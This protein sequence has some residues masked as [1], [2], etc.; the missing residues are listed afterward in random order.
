MGRREKPVDPA[1]GPVQRFAFELRKLRQEAGGPT[2]RAMARDAGYSVAAL[3]AAASGEKLP[4]LPVALAYAEAC[5][6]DRGEWE[7][8]WR[9]AADEERRA[10]G[11]GEDDEDGAGPPYRGL[12]RYEPGDSELFF[13]RDGLV[14]DLVELALA[15]RCVAVLGPS[16][17][18]K[19]SLLRAGLIPRL[20]QAREGLPR[21]AAIR[22]LTPGARP[23]S[24]HRERL[25]P[26]A[27]DGDTWVVVDQFE[28]VFTLCSDPAER[29][30][31]VDALLAAEAPGSRLRVVLGVR[32]DFYGRCLRHRGLTAVLS[33]AS[34][35]VGP[36]GAEELRQV[37]V[38][39]AAARGLVVERALTATLVAEAGGDVGGLPLMSH[40]LLETWRRRRGR[41]LTM[42]GY[43]A[44]GGLHGA[45]AQTAEGL[46]ARLTPEQ[47]LLVRRVLLRLVAPG[48][49]APDTR[50]PAGRA[51]L[52]AALGDGAGQ[53]LERLCRARLITLDGHGVELAHEALL[54]AWPRL[55]GW[56]EEDRRRLVLRHR[57]ARAADGWREVGRD[58]GALYRGLRLA[59]AL[60]A[61][62]PPGGAVDLAPGEREFLLASRA[63][64]ARERR[65]HRASVAAV[66]AVV[67]LALLAGVVAW[68]ENREGDRRRAEAGA[69][70][71]AVL[72]ASMR[73]SD[74]VL[75][76]RL[77]VAAWRVSDTAETR[78][79]LFDA[80]TQAHQD[81]LPV[82][83]DVGAGQ[84]FLGAEGRT[85]TT[86]SPNAGESFK[87]GAPL[88][89]WDVPARE[90]ATSASVFLPPGSQ[91]D[92][93]PDG[94]LV[95][96]GSE[97]AVSVFDVSSGDPVGADLRPAGGSGP[98]SAAFNPS[99]RTVTV[100][101]NGSLRLWDVERRRPLFERGVRPRFV[102]HAGAGADR[103]DTPTGAPGAGARLAR[104]AVSPDDRLAAL[105]TAA[106][107]F[108]VWDVRAGRR[109]DAPWVRAAAP[110]AC[111]SPRPMRFGPHGRR[112][113]VLTGDAV[114]MWDTATG[115]QLPELRTEAPRE[116]AFSADGGYAAVSGDTGIRMW[117]IDGRPREVFRFTPRQERVAQLRIDAA[118]G[119]VR[120]L[121]SS[122]GAVLAVRTVSFARGPAAPRREEYADAAQLSPDGR[123]LA[124][125]VRA[126]DRF[127]VELRPTRAGGRRLRLPA[128]SCA[129]A[130]VGE[131]TVLTAFSA[132]GRRFAYA[133][134]P[135]GGADG[136]GHRVRV[137]IWDTV[138]PRQKAYL[139]VTGD[140]AERPVAGI[141]LDPRGVRLLAHRFGASRWEEWDIRRGVRV[142]IRLTS[143]PRP[144]R[145]PSS[146]GLFLRPDGRLLATV[147]GQVAELPSGRDLSRPLSPETVTVL[148]FSPVGDRLAAGDEAGWVSLWDA[149]A[150]QR[151]GVLAGT[152]R[153]EAW[154]DADPVTALAF[155]PDGSMLA[156][157]GARGTLRLW[158]VATARPV[159]S[160]VPTFG[161][162][163]RDLVFSRDGRTLLLAGTHVA[164]RRY[165]VDP[166]RVAVSVCG[167]TG[168]GLTREQWRVHL[169]E[170]PYREV[171]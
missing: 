40:A 169:P 168:G 153:D 97:D 63:A 128:V 102:R 67:V 118:R 6:G 104:V 170:V 120:Y 20:R 15:R 131:C 36:M 47:R 10:A 145:A 65:R 113:A 157:G 39:P 42:E 74:P 125:A 108:Q 105:C 29:E 171:C 54:S 101:G 23:W 26:A 11:P 160:F 3:A 33:R 41:T 18:G 91:V 144:G 64:V 155:S 93:S 162:A 139:D 25:L 80:A 166:G 22:V 52:E 127:E 62:G 150:G 43:R 119:V 46:Y 7:R 146:R 70:R 37:V 85:M 19:S 126:G 151:L 133:A 87:A 94:R 137:R 4:S 48:E 109:V 124:R 12:A 58:P 111:S 32:A 76:M 129:P 71:I 49:G 116:L 156:V 89:R 135:R 164:L 142:S 96:A 61:F 103:G 115:G 14:D 117:R 8:R 147:H 34:V 79:A 138:R 136:R 21:P 90:A 99:G 132:D 59:E 28:E 5:G 122:G 86:L 51:E 16:G 141:A 154:Q 78:A 121:A 83:D 82:P 45:I 88:R 24:T 13:G 35:P 100:A 69:R 159:G 167:R 163:I 110:S 27:D 60:E 66:A 50:R 140:V 143:P 55:R 30:G 72:A 68:Q 123:L 75:A 38:K 57:L 106:G 152:V 98:V 31:F 53:V 56:I 149:D 107:G 2:Y 148:G 1:A 114:R 9:A 165:S 81:L 130:R 44:A 92:V 17:S 161:E 95:L 112:F 84:V 77:S 158:D 134:A 73:A